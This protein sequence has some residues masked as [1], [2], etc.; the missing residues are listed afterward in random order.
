MYNYAYVHKGE[1]GCGE[2]AF[3]LSRKPAEYSVLASKEIMAIDGS[4]PETGSPIICGSCGKMCRD[5]KTKYIEP[6][7][8]I[9]AE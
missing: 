1:G 8:N 6:R 9:K 7:I 5:L 2:Y 3:Y 4:T